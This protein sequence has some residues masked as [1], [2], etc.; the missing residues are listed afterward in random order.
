MRGR[1]ERGPDD[2]SFS[3]A[4]LASKAMVGAHGAGKYLAALAT[5]D[6]AGDAEIERRRAICRACP[7]RQRK[8]LPGMDAEADWCGPALEEIADPPSCGCLIYGKTSVGSEA[9]PQGKWGGESP[10]GPGPEK[11]SDSSC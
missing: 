7:T 1:R 9:C 8:K 5:G 3:L 4:Q 2:L 11:P 10:V 6:R